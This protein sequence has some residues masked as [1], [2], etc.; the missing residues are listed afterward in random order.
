MRST[1]VGWGRRATIAVALLL[2]TP[3]LLWA[4]AGIT[5]TPHP[6]A[7]TLRTSGDVE[8]P[9]GTRQELVIVLGGSARIAGSVGV[10]AVV[11]GRAELA[12][13]RV[14]QLVVVNGVARM[15]AGA[16]VTGDVDLVESSLS[17]SEDATIGGE[18]VRSTVAG[19]GGALRRFTITMLI[20][21]WIALMLGAQAFALLGG[22]AARRAGRVLTGQPAA[23]ALSA[24]V[25]WIG[26]PAACIALLATGFGIPMG[27]GWFV[28]VLPLLAALG[29]VLAALRLGELILESAHRPDPR[30]APLAAALVGTGAL[31]L[32]SL[33]PLL[34][35]FVVPLAAVMGSGALGVVLWERARRGMLPRGGDI[36]ALSILSIISRP[37]ASVREHT[38]A[39]V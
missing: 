29:W 2:L 15:T 10:L 5:V 8:V 14:D 7:A 23:V 33:T 17:Q 18:V 35:A 13:A 21:T 25:L 36:S 39:G 11:D 38:P 27:I 6:F 19:L 20:G 12:G 37:A 16:R 4:Q 26:M 22:E 31:L 24:A 9:A 32:A 1:H 28:F 3:A 30:R 34:S